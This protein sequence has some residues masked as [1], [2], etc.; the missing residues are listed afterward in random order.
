VR[1]PCWPRRRRLKVKLITLPLPGGPGETAVTSL[2]A[3]SFMGV[4]ARA[5]SWQAAERWQ[6]WYTPKPEEHEAHLS[7][8]NDVT[9]EGW[10]GD[11]AVEFAD[12]L[13]QVAEAQL[14]ALRLELATWAYGSERLYLN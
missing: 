13:R 12:V 3:S 14:W 9:G 2:P 6:P 10:H 8:I 4:P 7:I 5:L 11:D 1:I